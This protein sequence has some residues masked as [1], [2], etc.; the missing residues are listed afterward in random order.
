[1]YARIT[2]YK[3][4]PESITAAT[5]LVERLRP[6]IMAMPGVLRF[7]NCMDETGAGYVVSIVE[8]KETSDSNTEAVQ[9]MWG[10]FADYLEEPPVPQGFGVISDWTT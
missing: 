2:N 5:E 3:M 8:S 1:M 10:Q 6:Q 7:I 4:K 9:A